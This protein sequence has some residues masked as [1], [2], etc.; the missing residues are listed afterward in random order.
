MI[1]IGLIV[2]VQLFAILKQIEKGNNSPTKHPRGNEY[3][4]RY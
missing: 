2:I 4:R 3:N 1:V